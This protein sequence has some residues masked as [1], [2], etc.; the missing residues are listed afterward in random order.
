[1]M[2]GLAIFLEISL[3][4]SRGHYGLVPYLQDAQIVLRIVRILHSH[5]PEAPIRLA[6]QGLD[7]STQIDH[8]TGDAAG[9]ENVHQSG[10]S[11]SLGNPAEIHLHPFQAKLHPSF[12]CWT[13][14]RLER[15][16]CPGD[17]RTSW[18]LCLLFLIVDLPCIHQGKQF[19]DLFLCR[20]PMFS[21]VEAPGL[22][23]GVDGNIKSSLRG[24]PQFQ[25]SLYQCI[26]IPCHIASALCIDF[27]QLA[28]GI[29]GRQ[30]GIQ[31]IDFLLRL[32]CRLLPHL[33]IPIN[34]QGHVGIHGVDLPCGSRWIPCL[35]LSLIPGFLL[36]LIFCPLSCLLP[37]LAS[38]L[39]SCFLLC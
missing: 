22:H 37:C 19:L 1:M 20:Y 2:V 5:P 29:L 13:V 25:G 31:A 7:I 10:G 9:L 11:I 38:C 26:Q 17:A 15:F 39:H 32:V 14:V 21:S 34:R 8:G 3:V 12:P 36:S 24:L 30:K 4:S 6:S 16:R 35:V 18:G 27:R 23:Q 33:S 28:G